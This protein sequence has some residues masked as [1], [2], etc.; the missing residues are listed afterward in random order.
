MSL[1]VENTKEFMEYKN[2]FDRC[3]LE[4][5]GTKKENNE[6]YFIVKKLYF[7]LLSSRSSGDLV[8]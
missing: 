6:K 8:G 1:E 4:L 3:G 7:L 2:F 5:V